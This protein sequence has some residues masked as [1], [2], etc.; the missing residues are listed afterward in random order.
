M[1]VAVDSCR[2]RVGTAR[3][4]NDQG[5]HQSFIHD[6]IDLTSMTQQKIQARAVV[7]RGGGA[8]DKRLDLVLESVGVRNIC[9]KT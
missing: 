5:G 2:Q 4:H 8:D 3:N 7:R 1:A 9:N 6:A